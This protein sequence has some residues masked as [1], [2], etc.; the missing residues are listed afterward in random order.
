MAQAFT[1]GSCGLVRP[2]G[3]I[4]SVTQR[5]GAAL[6]HDLD[7]QAAIE[8][9]GRVASHSLKPILS[10]LDQRLD[11]GVVLF[12]IHRAVDVIRPRAAGADLVVTRLEPRLV[13]VD[14]VAVDDGRDG[15][16][17]GEGLGAGERADGLRQGR[18]EVR[19]PVAMMVRAPFLRRQALDLLPRSIVTRGCASRAAVTAAWR[20]R[21]GQRPAPR[22]PGPGCASAARRIS[23]PSVRI[24]WCNRPTALPLASSERNEFEQTSSA[25]SP[26]R[27]APPCRAP[28]RISWRNDR[29][30]RL[31]AICQAASDPAR[32]PP[33]IWMGEVSARS[34]MVTGVDP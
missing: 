19:G 22:R 25:R 30:G 9:G 7:R 34:V 24:S 32:P 16:E 20:S 2:T 27:Y 18:G 28:G 23:D 11:E 12:A 31:S 13:H 29:N 21:R 3:F 15:I 26:A 17:K 6:G 4:G 8:I 10:P 33:T 1:V 5:L 14:G